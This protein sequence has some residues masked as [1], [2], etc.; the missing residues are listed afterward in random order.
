MKNDKLEEL[1]DYIKIP[2]WIFLIISTGIFSGLYY[3][4]QYKLKVSN[5]KHE[6][7]IE[8]LNTR[9]ELEVE[10]LKMSY[11]DLKETYYFTLEENI[12]LLEDI[13]EYK[14]KISKQKDKIS[15]Y[16]LTLTNSSVI[17]T[18]EYTEEEV[19]LLAQCVQAEAG[20]YEYA[21]M[22][23]KMV[24]KVIL[25][26]VASKDFPNTIKD[27]IYQKVDKLPQ[28]SVA[29]DD[30]LERQEVTAE[31]M[32]NVLSVLLFDYNM[33]SDVLYFYAS[34]VDNNWV[35]KLAVYK[36]VQGT[37]FAYDYYK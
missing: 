22:S 8:E 3:S 21:D 16:K 35:N 9:Y 34:Y 29:Y 15:D 33:P 20:H 11:S 31:T 5:A 26:R 23:Q 10:D 4:S 30:A 6:A 25:N 37:T 1:K 17:P 14:D 32:A 27:V 19:Y 12:Q 24:T 28:F 2:M 7:E 36:T 18:Y 13:K